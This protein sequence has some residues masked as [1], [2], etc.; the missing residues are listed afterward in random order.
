MLINIPTMKELNELVFLMSPTSTSEPDGMNGYFFQKCLHIIKQDLLGVIFA[1]FSGQMI[2]K[3]FSHSCI[4][5]LPKVS[6]RNKLKEYR[7]ISLSDFTSKILSKVVSSRLSPILLTLVSLNQLGLVKGRKISEN[8]M[9]AQEIIYKIRKP[10]IKSSI[11]IKLDMAKSYDRV[12]WAYICLVLKKMI[13]DEKIVDMVWRI[14]TNN[15]YYI[16]ISGKRYGFFHSTRGLKQGYPLSPALF[17]FGAIVLS[18]ILNQL[19]NNS[20]FH[21]FSIEKRGQW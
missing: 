19:N 14:I 7:P 10:N 1:S 5:L 18:R 21:C 11:I 8:I 9:L 20:D 4:I 12:Y 2:H 15:W 16:I 6:N 3:H 13:F 17:I